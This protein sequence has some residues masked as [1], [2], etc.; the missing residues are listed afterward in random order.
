MKRA[1]LVSSVVFGA[2]VMV[3]EVTESAERVKASEVSAWGGISMCSRDFTASR[4]EFSDEA[5]YQFRLNSLSE[6]RRS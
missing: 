5:A 6:Y 3:I 1:Q 4:K 2:V